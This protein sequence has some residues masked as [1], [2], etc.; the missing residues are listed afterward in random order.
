MQS[1]ENYPPGDSQMLQLKWMLSAGLS[2]VILVGLSLNGSAIE[3]TTNGGF[4]TGDFTGWSQFPTGVDQ[5][6]VTNVNPSSGT[7]AVEIFN[8]IQPSNSL[9]K[10]ANLAAG[11]LTPGQT[12]TISFDARGVFGIGGVAFAELFSELTGGG[13]SKAEILSGGPLA[14]NIDS[15]VWT[16]FFFT[17][18][19]GTDV[20]GGVTLQLGA[21]NG[22]VVGETTTV[23]YD[24]VSV[25]VDSLT[26]SEPADLNMDGF[27]DGLD[28]GILLGNFNSVALPSGGELNL[29]DPV[30]GLDLG[31]LLGAWAPVPLSVASIPEPSSLLLISLAGLAKIGRRRQRS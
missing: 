26:F 25:S 23:W 31:I 12:V 20:S 10:Q 9:M 14:M 7:Y 8:D 17:T 16:N 21:T 19:L 30:D 3:L 27:V 28:L 24:N 4:E 6:T 2:L 15:N 13:V 1:I 11:G 22:A 5:Q 29:T 18:S